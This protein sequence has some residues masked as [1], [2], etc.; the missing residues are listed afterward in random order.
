LD[1][2]WATAGGHGDIILKKNLRPKIPGR[3]I[4]ICA[5]PFAADKSRGRRSVSHPAKLFVSW[6]ASQVNRIIVRGGMLITKD[7]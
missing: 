2:V 3:D 6:S 4:E 5:F 1:A 7:F